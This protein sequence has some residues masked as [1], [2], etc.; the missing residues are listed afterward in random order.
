MR[1]IHTSDWHLGHTLGTFS[2]TLEH[3]AFLDWL[4]E[5]LEEHGVDAL[6]I[7]GDVFDSAN[8][9]ASAQG[10]WFAFLAAV[11]RRLPALQVLVVGGNHDSAARLDAPGPVLEDLSVRVVGGVPRRDGEIAWE[12]MVLPLRGASGQ[13]EALVAAVPFLRGS[14]LPQVGEDEDPLIEG[15]R[16]FYARV[17]TAA[18]TRRAEGQ[19]LVGTGHCYLVGGALSSDSERVIQRGNQAALPADIFGPELDYVALGHLHRPQQV[20]SPRLRYSGSPISLSVTERDYPHQVLLVDLDGGALAGVTPLLFPPPVRLIRIPERGAA[21]SEV[22]LAACRE[23]PAAGDLPRDQWPL[24]ELW[25]AQREPDLGL[26][27]AVDQ[28]LEGRAARLVHMRVRAEGTGAALGDGE[29]AQ[30]LEDL[31]LEEVFRLAWT[32]HY[33]DGPDED[34][35][36]LFAELQERVALGGGEL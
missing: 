29:E 21:A 3:Q 10:M 19:A 2:R 14:D 13:V 1:L 8:P 17:V 6:L 32:R 11:H 28:A 7:A 4:A 33:A 27:A 23:L 20:G 15:T 26:R 35:L 31:A 25:V 30:R 22:V 36:M 12:E 16:A 9:P 24:V 5:R 34:D 18:A